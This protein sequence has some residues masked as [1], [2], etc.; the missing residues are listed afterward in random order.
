MKTPLKGNFLGIY[1]I[2]PVSEELT[3]MFINK[4]FKGL[5]LAKADP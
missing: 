1:G 3:L 4:R 5:C 2:N